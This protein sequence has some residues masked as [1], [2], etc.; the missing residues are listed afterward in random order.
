MRSTVNITV[1]PTVTRLTTLQRVK[2]ELAITDGAS[3]AILGAKI[4]EA[5]SDIEAHLARTLSRATVTQTLWNVG[6]SEY[7]LLRRFPVASIVSVTVDDIAVDSD[8]YRLDGDAGILYRLDSSGYPCAWLSC[9]SIVAVY[10][11]G[12]LLPGEMNRNLPPALESAAVELVA[13]Y[14]SSR[15]RDP[16]V[17]SEEVPGLGRVDY[18]VGAVGEAGELPPSVVAKISPFR[19]PSA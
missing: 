2:E 12:Y 10:T 15:G 18:W 3:D 13:S 14:W 5:T 4:D 11:G 7:I 6:Y 17:K 9:K 8:E 16:T 1:A 19:R